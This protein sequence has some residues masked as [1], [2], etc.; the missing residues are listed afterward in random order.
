MNKK[1]KSIISICAF[2]AQMLVCSC[3]SSSAPQQN[4]DRSEVTLA[5]DAPAVADGINFTIANNYFFRSDATI[6][7][8]PKITTQEQFDSL[9]GA[10]AVMGEGG[11]PT[12]IDFTKQFVIAVVLPETDIETSLSPVSL[13]KEDDVLTFTYKC[14]QGEKRSYTTQPVLA[15]VV[16]KSQETDIVKLNQQ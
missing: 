12:E 6:P 2:F 14:Q 11:Q 4:A 13:T 10:A 7:E 3:N 5:E 1:T 16:D 15:I 9:F 8:S